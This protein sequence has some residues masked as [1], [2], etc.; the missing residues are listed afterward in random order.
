METLLI[1]LLAGLGFIVAYH[2]Y[3]RWLGKKIFRLSASAVCPSEKLEDG[4][5]Y[6]PTHNRQSSSVE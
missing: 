4:V 6:V 5:D 3:G 2:T 1:A